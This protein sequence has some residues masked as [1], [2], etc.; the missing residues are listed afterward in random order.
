[1][2]RSTP[3][4]AEVMDSRGKPRESDEDILGKLVE[5]GNSRQYAIYQALKNNR[6]LTFN[7]LAEEVNDAMARNTVQRYL[8]EMKTEG[9]VEQ[10]PPDEEWRRGQPKKF[11]L[12]LEA[13]RAL[14]DAIEDLKVAKID[15]IYGYQWNEDTEEVTLRE[16]APGHL[17][18]TALETY[19]NNPNVDHVAL[20]EEHAEK[21]LGETLYKFEDSDTVPEAF[22]KLYEQ[23]VQVAAGEVL[24]RV[25]MSIS[26][27]TYEMKQAVMMAGCA[28]VAEYSEFWN[29]IW[30]N[31]WD[32]PHPAV[33]N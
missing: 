9:I 25:F 26:S 24:S 8:E 28:E 12:S 27:L 32:V 14:S 10:T 16:D 30:K 17:W 21:M 13:N 4:P 33:D 5:E 15:Y 18:V 23:T 19:H 20:C 6:E 31:S 1:M 22:E 29:D 7:Q 3:D 11:S 2:E